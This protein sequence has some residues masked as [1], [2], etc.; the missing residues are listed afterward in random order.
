[1]GNPE[2]HTW[3]KLERQ[4]QKIGDHAVIR[5]AQG[6]FCSGWHPAA[7]AAAGR[8]PRARGAADRDSDQ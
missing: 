7:S 1:M 2:E 4:R 5:L 8:C 6:G 3:Q